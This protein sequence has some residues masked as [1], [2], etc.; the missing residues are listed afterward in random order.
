MIL[1]FTDSTA[2]FVT[3]KFQ[4]NKHPP[5]ATSPHQVGPS[6][7]SAISSTGQKPRTSL[8]YVT[9]LLNQS[10]GEEMCKEM[11]MQVGYRQHHSPDR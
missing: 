8:Y 11:E 10:I 4:A 6:A 2:Y 3:L 7:S 1:V 5:L 9:T